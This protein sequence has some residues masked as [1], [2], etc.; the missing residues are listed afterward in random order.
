MADIVKNEIVLLTYEQ[1]V[2]DGGA[3]KQRYLATVRE[4]K[5]ILICSLA[6]FEGFNKNILPIIR[7]QLKQRRETLIAAGSIGDALGLPQSGTVQAS[8]T[9]AVNLTKRQRPTIN[10]P[11][12][13]ESIRPEPVLSQNDYEYVL[14]IMRLM[15]E[16]MEKAPEV[17][18]FHG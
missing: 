12:T 5:G 17:F 15:S 11:Q 2:P 14:R 3:I 6:N 1:E 7:R 16:T 9:Y 18:R 4:I 10:L 8:Q 13:A